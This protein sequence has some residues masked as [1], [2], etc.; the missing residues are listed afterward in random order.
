MSMDI[1]WLCR[2]LRFLKEFLNSGHASAFFG[3]FNTVP[4]KDVKVPFLIEREGIFYSREP[5]V[6]KR[7]QRPGRCPEKVDHGKVAIRREGQ[8]ADDGGN[9]KFVGSEHKAN[10][11]GNKP[12]ERSFPGE[13]GLKLT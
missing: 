4:Y 6:P 8:V 1:L 2:I 10:G 7:I 12:A 13:A 11:N 5:T 9:A 3:L